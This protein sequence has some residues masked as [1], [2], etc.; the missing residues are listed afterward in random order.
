[1]QAC[2]RGLRKY[3]YQLVED[4]E[5]IISIKGQSIT[6]PF[7]ELHTNGLIIIKNKYC[8]DGPS[9]PTFDT[10][11]FMRGSLV[12]DTLYQLMRMGLLDISYRDQS[13]RILQQICLE[14]GMIRF[15][16][17]Y[18]YRSVKRFAAKSAKPGTQKLDKIVRVPV[19]E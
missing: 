2:Y 11:T 7:I 14:D 17:W 6:T 13:D 9:G 3:K 12:H 19:K 4:Y 15:R 5:V 16:A 10:L 18:V 8:W 1:M